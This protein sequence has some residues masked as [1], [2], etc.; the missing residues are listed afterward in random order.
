MN[1]A[2]AGDMEFSKRDGIWERHMGEAGRLQRKLLD[3]RPR[4]T[5]HLEP[6]QNSR[7]QTRAFQTEKSQHTRIVIAT[8]SI[9]WSGR[10]VAG[11]RP[12]ANNPPG[13]THA[14]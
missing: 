1:T 13:D 12:Q 6:L 3:L 11:E 7:V 2:R 4:R 8:L 9:G 5:R 14:L 10:L